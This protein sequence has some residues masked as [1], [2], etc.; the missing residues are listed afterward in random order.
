MAV[1]RGKEY[2]EEEVYNH[3][4]DLIR[5]WFREK[6]GRFT[7]PQKY[8]I[9]ETARKNN[10][11]ITSP[12]G[13]GKT[14]SA[15]LAAIN[16]L[17]ILARE[18]KLED[19]VYVL[20]VSPLKALN[21]DIKRNLEQ[22]LR[23][24]YSLA[25]EEGIELQE[26]RLGVRTGD[27]DQSERQNQMKNPPHIFITTPESLAI[28]LSTPKFSKLLERIDYLII[29]EIHSLA[30]N[31]RGTHLS[32]SVERLEKR[33]KGRM[34]RIGL[35]A[36]IHPV[37]EVA[38][39]LVGFDDDGKERDCVIADV[40]YAKEIEIKVLS[41]VD[42]M[43][44]TPSE[45]MS[46]R[47]YREIARLIKQARTTLIF[48]NTRSAT[49]RVVYN[50]KKRLGD[51]YVIGAHHSSLSKQTRLDVEEKLKKGEMK[52]VVC[53]T[54]LELGIDVGYIDQVILLGSPKSIS[55]A[56]QRVGRSGHRLHD[57]SI[58]KIIVL[59][60]DDLVECTVLAK[61][62]LDRNLDRI[63]IPEKPLDVLVQH[64][65]GMAL[66][67]VWKIDEAYRL[68]KRSYPYRNLTME[69]FL[70]VL[71]YLSGHY[72]ELEKKRVYGKIWLDLDSGEFGKRGRMARPIYYLNIGVI[73]DEVSVRVVTKG[74]KR[75]GKVEEEFAERLIPG[76]IFVL[77]GK[78]YRFLGSKGMR[79]IVEEAEGE[80]PTVPSWFSE[81]LPL[82]YD[83]GMK[84]MEFRGKMKEM[85]DDEE[86]L[87]RYLIEEYHAERKT[88]EAIYNYFYEQEMFSEI[89]TEKTL[90]VE[91]FI[92]DRSRHSYVFH[93]VVGRRASSAIARVLAYRAGRITGRN[94]GVVIGDNGFV[95]TLSEEISPHEIASI[96]QTDNFR[97]D[98]KQAIEKTEI[99][100]RR[101]R[102]VS[103]RSLLVL[104]NYLG[105]EKSVWRQQMDSET[106]M[107]IIKKL[108]PEFPVLR[109]AY[110]EIMEDSMEVDNAMH[111]LKKIEEGETEFRFVDLPSPSPFSFNLIA[112]G[113]SDI[114]LMED[115]K[116]FIQKLHARVLEAIKNAESG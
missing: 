24:I 37:E 108:D 42:D 106:L 14:L 23:E 19:R 56:L 109:E 51:E 8:A 6:Y 71:R 21:N 76:D 107:G 95:L 52:C 64:I 81:Q 33:Q 69:E 57:R 63:R 102:H 68:I 47:M 113:E 62:A 84:I 93:A 111:Y 88:A 116:A 90:L 67:K 2:G 26:I 105:R 28:I 97:E 5:R 7:P 82:S 49:E 89:P 29:D 70:S 61:E 92:D 87:L 96:L 44:Y 4:D 103:V 65:L 73:P 43:I 101:F 85:L 15:F 31:K 9:V 11:L 34:V 17:I 35:S 32:L 40:A 48:T 54:S 25:E 100:K 75:L 41:P 110:R 55:R 60:Q 1:I 53:S 18:N 3:L 104:R 94:V 39:F 112:L 13:S 22:P 59:D 74:G 77:G 27:T 50:L 16:R 115:R 58:G 46:D 80:R 72:S 83:L 99:L 45:E 20:Y 38:K 12:T 66:E 98:L 79:I 78:T 36:T 10:I 91:H 30:E 114:V 86:A